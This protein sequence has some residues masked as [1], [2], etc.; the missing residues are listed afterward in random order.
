MRGRA[1]Q[2][3]A[4]GAWPPGYTAGLLM[5]LGAGHGGR[6]ALQKPG[7]GRLLRCASG[8]IVPL[9]TLRVSL[10]GCQHFEWS[11][12]GRRCC[13]RLTPRPWQM[14]SRLLQCEMWWGRM[15]TMMP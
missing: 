12:R 3:G 5:L 10:P 9:A 7:A 15:L 1:E 14:A 4:S 6:Q 11:V 2:T 8:I 13:H